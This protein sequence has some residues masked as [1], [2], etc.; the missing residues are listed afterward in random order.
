M[1]DGAEADDQQT[2]DAAA[3]LD[4]IAVYP[5]KSLDPEYVERTQL[6]ENGGLS[7]DREYAIFDAD[8]N[9]VN[10][11]RERAIHRIRSSVSLDDDTIRLSAPDCDD[12]DGPIADADDW[13]STYFGYDVELR[14]DSSGGFPDDTT[15]SGPTVISTATLE[16]VASW[17]DGI[18]TDEMRRRLRPNLELDAPDPFWEDHLFDRRETGVEFSIGL[19]SFVGINPCQRCVVP[20]RDPDTGEATPAF[21]ETFVTK[22]RETL[23]P[24]SGGDWF[25]HDFRLMVNTVVPESSWGETLTVADDVTVGDVVSADSL[26]LA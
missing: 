11:K 7:G 24:W 2:A 23:P 25:D 14:R 6:V 8:G 20:T 5:V 4:R 9:Y 17:F 26:G 10:G 22:R 19:A 15:A 3:T 13:L 16:R 21:R 1:T 12:Y 18:D